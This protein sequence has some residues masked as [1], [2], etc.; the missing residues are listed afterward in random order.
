MNF[1]HK[2]IFLNKY[3]LSK[4]CVIKEGLRETSL[5]SSILCTQNAYLAV[6]KHLEFEQ[7]LSVF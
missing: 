6:K 3:I 4:Y 1:L 5:T 7:N 2:V